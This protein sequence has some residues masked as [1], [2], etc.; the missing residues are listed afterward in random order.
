MK[1]RAFFASAFELQ[2]G[3]NW[4]HVL[5]ANGLSVA[6]G[7]KNSDSVSN[8]ED[9]EFLFGMRSKCDAIVVSAK[10]A[11]AENYRPSKFAPIF[12]IDRN[13]TETARKLARVADGEKHA[14]EVHRSVDDAIRRLPDGAQS[15]ILLECG[16]DMARSLCEDPHGTSRLVQA[17]ISVT[18]GSSDLGKRRAVE[19][20]EGLS[21]EWWLSEAIQEQNFYSSFTRD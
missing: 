17:L 15:K 2:P 16:R 20:V 5:S 6:A 4:I 21:T 3:L 13:S 19:L 14:I 9:R 10:T 18:T 12:I 1:S 11:I 8:S 7:T